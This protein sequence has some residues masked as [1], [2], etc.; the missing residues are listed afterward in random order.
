MTGRAR[1]DLVHHTVRAEDRQRASLRQDVHGRGLSGREGARRCGLARRARARQVQPERA[2]VCGR[3]AVVQVVDEG[4]DAAEV[5]AAVAVGVVV[6]G[7]PQLMGGASIPINN[8]NWILRWPIHSLNYAV[9][10]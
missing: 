4:E 1:A 2:A 9:R 5:G 7:R 8:H 3:P 6:V 10:V